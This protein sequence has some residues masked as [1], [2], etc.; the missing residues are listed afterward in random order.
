ME[1]KCSCC[2]KL[3]NVTENDIGIVSVSSGGCVLCQ[4]SAKFNYSYIKVFGTLE[5]REATKFYNVLN[6]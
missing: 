4:S 6:D 1:V 2:G 3:H 5:A